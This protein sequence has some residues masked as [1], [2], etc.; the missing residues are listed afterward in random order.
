MESDNRKTAVL[1][2]LMAPVVA[3]ERAAAERIEPIRKSRLSE[4]QTVEK[5]ADHLRKKA[6]TA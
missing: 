3:W 6:A 5:R 2:R 1:S 4:R